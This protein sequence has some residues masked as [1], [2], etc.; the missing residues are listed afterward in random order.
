MG[1]ASDNLFQVSIWGASPNSQKCV[2][3]VLYFESLVEQNSSA[4]QTCSGKDHPCYPSSPVGH[5]VPI[6]EGHI[7]ELSLLQILEAVGR[8]MGDLATKIF[9]TGNVLCAAFFEEDVITDILEC[10]NFE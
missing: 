6:S 2:G 4:P 10:E 9:M 1:S 3:A 8:S 7:S 5:Q